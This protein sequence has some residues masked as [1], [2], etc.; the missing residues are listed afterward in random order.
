MTLFRQSTQNNHPEKTTSDPAASFPKQ[1]D[2]RAPGLLSVSAFRAGLTN[3]HKS[4]IFSVCRN[5]IFAALKLLRKD[6]QAA[7]LLCY[8]ED[9]T[10]REI[11]KIMNIPL[12]TVKTNILKGKEKMGKFLIQ[13]G[14]GN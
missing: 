4:V 5:D 3:T 14:Y 13:A 11:S 10:H 8:M 1:S 2:C 9:K 12:G 6:E 7:I